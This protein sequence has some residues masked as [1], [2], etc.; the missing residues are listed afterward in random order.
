MPK[1]WMLRQRVRS[2]AGR[3]A[4]AAGAGSAWRLRSQAC[5]GRLAARIG[6]VMQWT[7]EQTAAELEAFENERTAFLRK[8]ARV[9]VVL[10]A[11]AD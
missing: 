1:R 3:C 9:D 11:V 2:H 7:S 5:S 4:A 6:A 8:P 10:E